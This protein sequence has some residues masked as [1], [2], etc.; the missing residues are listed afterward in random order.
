[1]QTLR[2]IMLVGSG[3]F[4]GSALRYLASGWIQHVV[5][6]ELIPVGT[7]VVNVTGCLVIG[8]LGGW[9]EHSQAF[10]PNTRLFLFVGLLGGFTTFSTFGYETISL[11]RDKA[12]LSSFVYI[13]VHLVLGLGA[14]LLG[15]Y[16]SKLL[17]S[18]P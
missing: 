7:A 12:I 10:S 5:K 3:G 9:A 15:L 8:L 4:V 13:G 16:C 11:L 1:M 6:T 14:V 18:Q 2:N 17:C